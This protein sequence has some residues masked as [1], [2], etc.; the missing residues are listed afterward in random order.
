MWPYLE[1]DKSISKEFAQELLDCLFVL[2]NH[3]NKTRD[4]VSDQAFAGYAVFQNFGVG[5]QTED[6]LDAT[7]P[8]SYM[9][10]DAAAHVR[11]PAPSFSVRIHNQTP[12]DLVLVF[13][14]CTMMKQSFLHYVTED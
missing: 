2:L 5:G 14:L 1:A 11:L 4:D 9:C 3:V 13:Q 8:V 6:G 10:M 12:D 7:N